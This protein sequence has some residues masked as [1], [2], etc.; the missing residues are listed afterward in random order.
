MLKSAW[1]LPI[2]INVPEEIFLGALGDNAD[3]FETGRHLEKLPQPL[4]ADRKL[5]P[6]QTQLS[7]LHPPSGDGTASRMGP[8]YDTEI[9][10]SCVFGT[11]PQF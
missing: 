10:A 4:A 2:N 8:R 3:K 11:S 5:S 6:G 7:T 9:R 1:Y